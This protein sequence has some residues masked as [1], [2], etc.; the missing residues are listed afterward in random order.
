MLYI[1]TIALHVCIFPLNV[2]SDI[3]GIMRIEEISEAVEVIAVFGS[4][5]VSPHRFRWRGKVYR[6]KHVNGNWSVDEGSVR[7]F[8]F[9]VQCEGPDVYDLSYN[10]RTHDWKI[11]KISVAA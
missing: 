3:G 8:H 5:K 2:I 10:S 4:G 11:E 1:L 9:A 6:V 7:L